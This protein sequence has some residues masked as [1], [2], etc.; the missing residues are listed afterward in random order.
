M[1]KRIAAVKVLPAFSYDP[2]WPN[3]PDH[4]VL[5]GKHRTDT[6]LLGSIE[7]LPTLQQG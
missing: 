3:G 7:T 2:C 4:R 6:T 1:A 5:P